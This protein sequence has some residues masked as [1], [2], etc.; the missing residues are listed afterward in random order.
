MN[1]FSFTVVIM[2]E[3]FC[4]N[5]DYYR[6]IFSILQL[7]LCDVIIIVQELGL[8]SLS[9]NLQLFMRLKNLTPPYNPHP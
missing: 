3:L 1:P 9:E 4:V 5:D 6:Q 2:R 7:Y 8:R